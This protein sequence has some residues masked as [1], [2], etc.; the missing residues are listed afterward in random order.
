LTENSID[1]LANETAGRPGKAPGARTL[2]VAC[3]QMEPRIGEKEANLE[4]SL[5][6]IG[7]AA[8]AGANLIV[9]PELCN[10]GYVFASREEA[11]ALS[12]PIEGGRTVIAWSEAARRHDV[13]IAAGMAERQGDKL[14]N[15]AV[16]VSPAGLV[17]HYRKNHLWAEEMLAF[18]PG[19]IGVP[20]FHT[21]RGRFALA[22]CYDLWFPETFRLAALAGADLL[23]VPTNWVPMPG[24]R[25]DLPV[26]ANILSMAGAHSNGIFV[27]AAD[28]IGVERGQPFLGRSL[29]VGP[30][31][32]PIAGPASADRE[33]ILLADIDLAQARQGRSLNRFNHIL[34]DRR[35]DVYGVDAA[36][37]RMAA[38]RG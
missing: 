19:D 18:E 35:P 28:R 13:L 14:Y 11:H 8:Q 31:G 2:R 29:I 15:S 26:M 34:R 36:P 3:L 38:Q 6:L 30:E 23:C 7:E 9:L 27:A 32:W 1:A 21:P 37:T 24:Q 4:R 12:E 25:Q 20:V 22:I 33:E 10:S 16:L 5:T 17:G